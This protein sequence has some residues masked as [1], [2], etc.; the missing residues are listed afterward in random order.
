MCQAQ[1]NLIPNPGFEDYSWCPPGGHGSIVHCE[2]WFTPYNTSTDLHHLCGGRQ[3]EIDRGGHQFPRTDSGMAAIWRMVT[4]NNCE[5]AAAKLQIPM[6]KDSTY[7]VQYYLNLADYSFFGCGNC[8]DALLTDT[9][10]DWSYPTALDLPHPATPQIR[11]AGMLSDTVGWTEV[12]DVYQARGGEQYLMIGSYVDH[13]DLDLLRIGEPLDS[14]E[15]FHFV[16]YYI[17]DVAVYQVPGG[18]D[19][20]YYSDTV[21]STSLPHTLTARAG[22][23]RY[24]WTTGDTTRSITVNEPG[25]YWVEQFIECFR[26]VDGH[27]VEVDTLHPAPDLGP[28]RYHCENDEVQPVLLDA[29]AQPRY[30]WSTGETSRSITVQDSGTYY[31]QVPYRFC[32]TQQDTVHLLGCP[33]NYAYRLTLPNVFSP[34]G[35][36]V[37]D[38]FVPMDLYNL[39]WELLRIYDRWGREV[40]AAASPQ[41]GWDGRHRGRDLPVG[42]Y[43]YQLHFRRPVT[44][45]ADLRK[46]TLTLLR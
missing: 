27:N 5:Y 16:Y 34:N 6:K 32:P 30:R 41:P 31:V 38:R 18:E 39:D 33:P 40:Y 35:D 29:G 45:E 42:V 36:G 8:A 9:L 37:N 19:F 24:Q 17:D 46:G 28:D 4:G 11:Q 7:V 23:Q 26:V 22:Y 43:Y 25:V 13:A 3:D 14:L 10:P 2:E 15:Y 21:C 1:P 20:R 12:C 44:G